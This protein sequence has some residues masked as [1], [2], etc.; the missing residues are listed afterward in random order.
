MCERSYAHVT[1]TYKIY[2]YK[3]LLTRFCLSTEL[4]SETLSNFMA[5]NIAIYIQRR[6][7]HISN[8]FLEQLILCVNRA[9][10][11]KLKSTAHTTATPLKIFSKNLH[12]N[13]FHDIK[14][15][16]FNSYSHVAMP[17]CIESISNSI[18]IKRLV[19][20]VCTSYGIRFFH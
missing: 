15:I 18:P 16:S 9:H 20:R 1:Y 3:T 12:S 6:F 2:T 13:V 11:N 5:H 19:T 14:V 10:W 7:I 17:S 4:S 8:C